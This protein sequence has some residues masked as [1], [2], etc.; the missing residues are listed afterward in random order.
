LHERR[1]EYVFQI[2]PL[3]YKQIF[4]TMQKQGIIQVYAV[5]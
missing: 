2:F 4:Q 3:W 5:S 1:T